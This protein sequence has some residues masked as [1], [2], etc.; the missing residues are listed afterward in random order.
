MELREVLQEKTRKA[1][2]KQKAEKE[3][4]MQEIAAF[5]K[6]R[7]S[8]SAENGNF[9]VYLYESDFPPELSPFTME[10]VAEFAKRNNLNYKNEGIGVIL[11]RDD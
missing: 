9:K 3:A 5:L 11:S 10:D 6:T 2:E 7:C 4:H 1:Q 8:K